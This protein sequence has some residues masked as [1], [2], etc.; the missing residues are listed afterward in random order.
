M[1]RRTVTGRLAFRAVLITILLLAA[2]GL[3]GIAGAEEGNGIVLRYSPKEGQVLKY[4][5]STTNEAFMQGNQFMKV[6]ADVVEISFARIVEEGKTAVKLK[7]LES[8]DKRGIEGSALE[9]F[10]SPIRTVGSSVEV[11]VNTSGKV[12][13]TNGLIPGIKRGEQTTEYVGKWFFELPSDTLAPGS[14]WTKELPEK[15]TATGEKKASEEVTGL[16]GTIVYEL[17]KVEKKDGIDVAI[18]KFKG[19]LKIHDIGER[20]V[21]D[22]EVKVEGEAK[23]AI[24]GG[25]AV[26]L[27]SSF[28][29]KGRAVSKDEFT[30]KETE[31]EVQQLRYS[32][33]KLEK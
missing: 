33:I 14:T 13:D 7:Y 10:E 29:M 8:S 11:T 20:G 17:K 5:G 28:E 15:E 30:G 12:L 3:P 2:E 6:H 24:D 23:I 9:D 22:G 19:D 27:K 25:Y 21:L 32:D 18:I 26:E 16:I 31:Q 1:G 4:K